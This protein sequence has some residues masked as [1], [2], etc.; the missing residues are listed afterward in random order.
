MG[1]EKEAKIRKPPKTTKPGTAEK[2][3]CMTSER[4]DV[5]NMRPRRIYPWIFFQKGDQGRELTLAKIG[6]PFIFDPTDY[7]SKIQNPKPSKIQTEM[8]E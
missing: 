6:T 5:M 3:D 4:R 1:N 2:H 7:N 8:N